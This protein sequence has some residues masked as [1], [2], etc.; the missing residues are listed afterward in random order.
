MN[1]LSQFLFL[2]TK[3]ALKRHKLFHVLPAPFS[4]NFKILESLMSSENVIWRHLPSN[5]NLIFL[6]FFL[7]FLSFTNCKQIGIHGRFW[8]EQFGNWKWNL[9]QR[10]AER[11]VRKMWSGFV[12]SK[13][14]LENMHFSRFFGSRL[15]IWNLRPF[16][17]KYFF[18]IASIKQLFFTEI[19]KL[20]TLFNYWKSQDFWEICIFSNF[21]TEKRKILVLKLNSFELKIYISH[22]IVLFSGLVELPQKRF[23]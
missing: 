23:L 1:S 6:F 22:N 10:W 14:F 5:F 8:E 15:K 13:I 16:Y 4:S 19:S 17:F 3:I 20:L 7:I 18:K 11:F 12:W 21:F 9:E 2:G